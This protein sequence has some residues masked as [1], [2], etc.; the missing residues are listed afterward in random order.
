MLN[1]DDDSAASVALSPR[2]GDVAGWSPDGTTLI[3]STGYQLGVGSGPYTISAVSLASGS[4]APRVTVL[5]TAA[6]SFPFIG[7]VRT[8]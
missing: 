4:G 1:L 5:T 6:T 2:V 3:F 8:A 7:F